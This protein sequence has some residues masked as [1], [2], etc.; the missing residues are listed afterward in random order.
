MHQYG[1]NLRFLPTL[2]SVFAD[3]VSHLLSPFLS[4]T[5]LGSL[6]ICMHS[7]FPVCCPFLF[8]FFENCTPIM[9]WIGISYIHVCIMSCV[10]LSLVFENLH[11]ATG[12]VFS[13]VV[14]VFFS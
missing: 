6:F 13:G 4:L 3:S 8:F 5:N 11:F 2:R 9:P 7:R 12:S 14:D 1:V 10:V